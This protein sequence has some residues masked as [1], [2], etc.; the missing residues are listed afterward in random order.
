MKKMTITVGIPA[1]NEEGNIV[2]LLHDLLAQDVKSYTIEKIIVA[3]DKSTDATDQLTKS[4]RNKKIVLLSTKKREGQAARQNQILLETKSDILVLLNA[5][6]RIPDKSFLEKIAAPIAKEDADLTSCETT[7]LSTH[8]FLANVLRTS[9]KVKKIMFESHQKGNNIYTCHGRAR[10][11]SKKLYKKIDFKKSVGEDAYS[12]LF[13]I[14]QKLRY[15]YVGNTNVFY[16]L[17]TNL[18]DHK[19]QSV[20]FLQSQK[21]LAKFFDEEVVRAEYRLPFSLIIKS[22]TSLFLNEPINVVSFLF[23]LGLMKFSSFFS[24]FSQN[25]WSIS[26]SSKVLLNK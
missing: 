23:I 16:R 11:F 26:R 20:R 15:Q 6:V 25:T 22:F 12:Y 8:G 1:Y 4:L 13:C 3:S 19:M 17:P 5:D 21:V 18:Q 10:A 24:D 9:I 14:T 2:L 7:P